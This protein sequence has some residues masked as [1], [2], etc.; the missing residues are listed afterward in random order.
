M[1]QSLAK[2]KR[3]AL[4]SYGFTIGEGLYTNKNAVR[5]DEVLDNLQLAEK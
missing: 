4:A 2:W 3:M 1:V 5:R